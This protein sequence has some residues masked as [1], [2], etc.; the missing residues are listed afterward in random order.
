MVRHG[1]QVGMIRHAPVITQDMDSI[2]EAV[3]KQVGNTIKLATPLAIGKANHVIN[4]FYRRAKL[5]PSIKLTILTAL[6]L[7]VPKGKSLLEKRFLEPFTKR[8]FGDYP[9][10]DYEL[11]RVEQK[12]PKNVHVIEF[13][14]PPGKFLNNPQA[15]QDYIS[16]N[17]THAVRDL[18]DR[19]ANVIAQL[20][21]PHESDPS[22]L[23][24]SGNPDIA[25]DLI[26]LMQERGERE[27]VPY[28]IVGQVNPNLPYMFGDA[29]IDAGNFHYL[30]D[31]PDCYFRIFGPPK[32]SIPD[33]EHV[34]GI[35]LSTLIRDEGELQIGIGA[36]GDAF[37][38][39]LIIRQKDN[40]R[41]REILELLGVE[42]RFGDII[43]RV[44]GTG[45]LEKGLF[46]ASEMV[47]DGFLNLYEAG[48]LNRMVYDDLHLQRLLNAGLIGH[49]VTPRTLE[50]LLEHKA[51]HVY[52]SRDD[53]DYLVKFGI[54][55]EELVF[56]NGYIV[57]PDGHRIRANFA[58]DA[59][60]R[61]ILELCLGDFLK[62]GAIVHGAFFMGPQSFY[63]KL[64][65]LPEEERRL[66]NMR[67][68]RRINHLYGH[69]EIDRLQ[70]K[71]ARF[72]NTC[73]KV[74]LAG[75]IVSDG[76]EDGRVIS[77]VGGQYNFVAMAHELHEGRSIINMR[78]TREEGGRTVSNIVPGYGHTTIPRH[79][80]D[81][82][83]NEYGIADL[84]GKTDGEI[85]EE[86]I[87][88]TDSR[89]Q[90]ELVEEAKKT[91]KLRADYKIPELFRNNFPEQVIAK[92]S[93]LNKDGL[94]TPFPFGTDFTDEELVVGKALKSLK[95]KT[96]SKRLLLRS[97]LKAIF[98]LKIPENQKTYLERM[99][100]WKPA[101]IEEWFYRN[102][103]V[104]EL[105]EVLKNR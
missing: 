48:I 36:M 30:F 58:S 99:K 5:D 96:K 83:V 62:G 16:S 9:D 44:G 60:R 49:E 22:R 69:E 40:A 1:G 54:F 103:L 27:N 75:N 3:I 65:A 53:F 32:L 50:L 42:K 7:E 80:R 74:T 86:L 31:N 18:M 72:I 63:Q 21:S 17:Y 85:I 6:T 88:I 28:A 13:Y 55:K 104:N 59:D 71:N 51:V 78:A 14:F 10:L 79:L 64:K 93:E 67:S 94:F 38:N 73:M 66:F 47:V 95:R 45:I 2:V 87:K 52:L 8:V 100:L 43:Q 12:L 33:Q 57:T 84:R 37:V 15:Q 76:L 105:K 4:A 34:V 81:I 82:I 11:D 92:F 35:Y 25:L 70:R 101:G 90:E 20:I 97:I 24:L 41:Y 68:V 98:I 29:E 91:G 26:R 46:G 77:G 19:G 61:E 23:S 89:F 56:D 102:L 39:A